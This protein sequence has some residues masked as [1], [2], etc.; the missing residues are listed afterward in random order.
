MAH[1]P[2]FRFIFCPAVPYSGAW[3]S[4]R[5]TS[6]AAPTRCVPPA[7][8]G[9]RAIR[10]WRWRARCPHRVRGRLRAG[11]DR[12]RRGYPRR[13]H[14]P[15]CRL[16]LPQDRAPPPP[17]CGCRSPSQPPRATPRRSLV[18]AASSVPPYLLARHT[19]YGRVRSLPLGGRHGSRRRRERRRRG[20]SRRHG[21]CRC[22]WGSCR[23]GGRPRRWGRSRRGGSP[24]LPVAPRHLVGRRRRRQPRQ[25]HGDSS[26]KLVPESGGYGLIHHHPTPDGHRL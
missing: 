18:S 9:P 13:P 3:P 23:R 7:A 11:A 4:V 26:S 8:P 10:R 24:R 5:G 12:R 22:R 21:R 1:L 25:W 14:A 2:E 16:P 6:P 20:G 19:S 17:A 15:S